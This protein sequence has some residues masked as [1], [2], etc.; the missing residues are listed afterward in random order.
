MVATTLMLLGSN[1]AAASAAGPE[2]LSDAVV[3]AANSSRDL[4]GTAQIAAYQRAARSDT[5]EG[6]KN[7]LC[8]EL[9]VSETNYF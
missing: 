3:S 6:S 1:P 2:S 7:N 4:T 5:P 9:L 8:P